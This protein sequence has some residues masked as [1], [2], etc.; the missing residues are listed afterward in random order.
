[1]TENG[2]L[3]EIVR[4]LLSLVS[5]WM[6]ESV[7]TAADL[8]GTMDELRRRAMRGV[9][10]RAKAR[11]QSEIR[12]ALETRQRPG[13]TDTRDLLRILQATAP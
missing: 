9:R 11:V 10:E 4:D 8:E 1:M 12:G 7:T 13:I 3:G 2:T 5:V 6:Q